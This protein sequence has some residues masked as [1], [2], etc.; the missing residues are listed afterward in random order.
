MQQTTSKSEPNQH[1]LF[2]PP[3]PNLNHYSNDFHILII[4]LIFFNFQVTN[5]G[6]RLLYF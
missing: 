1:N 3:M 4:L 5:H 6:F 2:F